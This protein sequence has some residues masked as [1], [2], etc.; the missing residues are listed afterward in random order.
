M[1]SAI[2]TSDR[3]AVKDMTGF[4][5]RLLVDFARVLTKP[6]PPVPVAAREV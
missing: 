6:Q 4:I 1:R 5:L 2:A 3:E